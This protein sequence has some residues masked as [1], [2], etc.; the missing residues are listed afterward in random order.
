[1]VA[2]I[3]GVQT[4]HVRFD[5]FD[6]TRTGTG[7]NSTIESAR[8]LLPSYLTRI[9]FDLTIWFDSARVK[10]SLKTMTYTS[11]PYDGTLGR[12]VVQELRVAN[13][14]VDRCCGDELIQMLTL[15]VVDDARAPRHE[16]NK[17]LGQVED[18]MTAR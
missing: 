14:W 17:S 8:F 13:K 4:E 5:R 6:G 11:L 9:P 12:G 7:A 15:T 16:G 1:M 3:K 18:S 10:L 2:T